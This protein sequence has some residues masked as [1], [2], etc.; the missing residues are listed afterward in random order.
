MEVE[1]LSTI[2]SA[3]IS[4]LYQVKAEQEAFDLRCSLL[5]RE[6]ADKL[7]AERKQEIKEKIEHRKR[8]EIAEAGRARNFWGN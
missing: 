6:E 3:T 5:P 2:L 7:R 4:T 1:M 8:L